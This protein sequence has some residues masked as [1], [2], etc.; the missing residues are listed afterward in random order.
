M[1]RYETLFLSVPEITTAEQEK[2]E[3]DFAALIETKQGKVKSFDRWGKYLLAYP[4]R[5][6]DYG[7]YYLA[8]FDIDSEY[9]GNI[10]TDITTYFKLRYSELVMR[11]MTSSL[12]ED[13][14]SEY[15]RP[16]S[17]DESIEG[18]G[19]DKFIKDNKM[20]DILKSSQQSAASETSDVSAKSEAVEQD[21]SDQ[22]VEQSEESATKETEAVVV[23]EQ[24]A[25]EV[26][27][28]VEEVVAVK[29]VAA[30]KEKVVSP[31]KP[32]KKQEVS[33]SKKEE[34]PVADA[35]DKTDED[36]TQDQ[37]KA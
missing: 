17:L 7:V 5:K 19:V 29:E 27:K 23:E 34:T 37:E 24:P 20:D 16:Q 3:R 35:V 30:K 22:T 9:E 21:S 11:L 32:S 28:V 33:D 18:G 12:D 14:P 4:V 26:E 8:R 6:N 2:L 10:H 15:K 36:T 13:A 31:V 1:V 25:V